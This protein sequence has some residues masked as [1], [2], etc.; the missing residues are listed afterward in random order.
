MKTC[1]TSGR[2][3]LGVAASLRA[4]LQFVH[5]QKSSWA[6]RLGKVWQ[7][8]F[9][10]LILE[11][12]SCVLRPVTIYSTGKAKP[13]ATRYLKVSELYNLYLIN[14]CVSS[15]ESKLHW[16]KQ[17]TPKWLGPNSVKKCNFHTHS[18]NNTLQQGHASYCEEISQPITTLL[19]WTIWF[20]VFNFFHKYCNPEIITFIVN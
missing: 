1:S 7:R 13:K 16:A 11:I 5:L 4:I 18:S 14:A 12:Q 8:D 17:M 20:F 10:Q 3:E 2:H 9:C 6:E 15:A 19:V